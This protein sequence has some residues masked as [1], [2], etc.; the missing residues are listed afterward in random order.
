MT[1]EEKEKEKLVAELLLANKE[2]EQSRMLL[3]YSLESQKDTIL[4]SIDREY[5]YLYF[6]KAHRNVMRFAYGAEIDLGMNMLECMSNLDDRRVAKENC[7]R[8]LGGESHTNIRMFGDIALAYYESFFN[9]IV[10]N[11]GEIIGATALARDISERKQ[12]EDALAVANRELKA[13]ERKLAEQ[14]T[15]RL[16]RSKQESEERYRRIV[17]T[18]EEGIWTIDAAS[19]TDFVNPKMA[20]MLGYTPEEM[21]GR[22]LQDFMSEEARLVAS[23]NVKRRQLGIAEQHEFTFLAKD[24]SEVWTSMATSPITNADGLYVGALAMVTDI[25]A[26]KR[27]EADRARLEAQL[28]Q[29]RKLES[30]GRLAGG[31]AHDFNNMLSVILGHAD[32]VLHGLDASD[33]LHA[34]LVAIRGAAERSAQLTRQLLAVARRQTI[35][36]ETLNVNDKVGAMLNLLRRLLGENLKLRWEPQ[37]Q[38]WPVRMDPSQLDQIV[39][40]LC[41]NARDAIADVG[42]VHIA[43]ANCIVDRTQCVDRPDLVP[44]EYLRL[45]VQ[46]DGSGIAP[47][48]L[49]H[50]FEPF[51]TTKGVGQGTGLG[52]ATV[53]GSVKQ[54]GGFIEVSSALGQGTTFRV[55]LPRY[56]DPL[57]AVA[58][59]PAQLAVGGDETILLVEDESAVLSLTTRMLVSRGYHVLSAN[60][61]SEALRLAKEHSGAIHLLITDVIMP[62]MNGRELAQVLSSQRPDL[63][64]LFMSGYTADVIS[65]HGVLAAGTH[66]LQKPFTPN[67]LAAKVR[68]TLDG[69]T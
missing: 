48:M 43:T 28:E 32:L 52:L 65:P 44:G 21:L 40:N 17:E 24:G 61:P 10:N 56:V 34:E 27:A 49:S 36:P 67:E 31:V 23:T 12:A 66:F 62:G 3:R 59:R 15:A 13:A 7:D 8:A 33:P 57:K 37:P 29:A 39:T 50:I 47:E 11:Q 26:R 58:M 20:H 68:E 60:S 46:D 14:E 51:F 5:R 1:P 22:P 35:A 2:L 54:S 45:T 64:K 42:T 18:A 30:V 16:T 4:F 63:K 19:V 53:Y 9:P 25:T 41:V 55:Y 6:N 38:P 69:R